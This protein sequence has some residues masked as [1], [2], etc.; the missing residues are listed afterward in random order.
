MV[1]TW[2]YVVAKVVGRS[3]IG[4]RG[5][6]SASLVVDEAGFLDGVVVNVTAAGEDGDVVERVARR[7]MGVEGAEGRDMLGG[8]RD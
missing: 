5:V 1:W 7:L 4:G 2:V 8:C 3:D 6:G